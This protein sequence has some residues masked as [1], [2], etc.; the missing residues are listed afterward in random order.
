M[1]KYKIMSSSKIEM[2]N[3]RGVFIT[4]EGIDGGGKSTQAELLTGYLKRCGY[5]VIYTREPGG[6]RIGDKIREILLDPLNREMRFLTELLLFSASR[7]Q[8]VLEK[9][10]PALQESKIVICSRFSDAT[11]AYQGYGRGLDLKLIAEL[12]RI[13]TGG[14]KPDLTILLDIEPSLGLKRVISADDTTRRGDYDRIEAGGLELQERVRRGFLSLAHEESER[15]RI[16]E[17]EGNIE[18][19]Q[20]IIRDIIDKFLE[21]RRNDL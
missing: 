10:V 8:H 11:V 7:A 12:N 2:E 21:A 5:E 17:V 13:A 4:L 19:T 15:F 14:L 20:Q 6:T 16:V 3:P 9:I 18:E 1:R